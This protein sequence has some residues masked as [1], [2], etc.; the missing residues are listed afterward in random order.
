MLALNER[1]KFKMAD[2]ALLDETTYK[3]LVN[4][5]RRKIIL[6]YFIMHC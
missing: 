5:Y 4:D 2:D 1:K 6:K 3:C